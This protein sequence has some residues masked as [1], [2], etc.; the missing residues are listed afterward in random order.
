ML[1]GTIVRTYPG[2]N[3][4]YAIPLIIATDAEKNTIYSISQMMFDRTSEEYDIDVADVTLDGAKLKLFGNTPIN[5][6]PGDIVTYENGKIK[7]T[8]GENIK[9]TILMR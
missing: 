4:Y 3:N 9:F 8:N 1:E 7:I 2:V 6:I 5:V